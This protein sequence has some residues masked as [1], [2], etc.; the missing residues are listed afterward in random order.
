MKLQTKISAI[1]TIAWSKCIIQWK[2]IS[3]HNIVTRKR[4]TSWLSL[5][6]TE[7]LFLWMVFN[8]GPKGNALFYIAHELWLEFLKVQILYY[9]TYSP[10]NFWTDKCGGGQTLRPVNWG[11]S[12]GVSVALS[13]AINPLSATIRTKNAHDF[14][15]R[16]LTLAS[17]NLGM[18]ILYR[19]SG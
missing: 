13:L 11:W 8:S 16:I 15:I 14:L 7:E 19:G 9:F 5:W 1:S 18:K 3:V 10:F 2:V 4:G 17:I 12:T 6:S